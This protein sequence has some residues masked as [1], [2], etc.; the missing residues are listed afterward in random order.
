MSEVL[1]RAREEGPQ[2]IGTTQ[3]GVVVSLPEWE[4]LNRAREPL[5]AWLVRTAPRLA[6]LWLPDRAAPDRPLDLA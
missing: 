1:R 2:L 5:G 3:P 4:E 6:E